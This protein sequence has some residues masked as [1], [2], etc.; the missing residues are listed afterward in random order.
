MVAEREAEFG[1]LYQF[2]PDRCCGLR[3]VEPLFKAV[4]QYRVWITGLRREQAR[5]RASL[6][7]AAMFALADGKQVLKMAPL[8]AWTTCDVWYAR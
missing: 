1:R 3:K 8:A 6:E 7:E 4:A 5:T 2:A